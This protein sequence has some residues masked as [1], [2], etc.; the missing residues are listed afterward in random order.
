MVP[1]LIRI[2]VNFFRFKHEN[3]LRLSV[4]LAFKVDLEI[5]PFVTLH[6]VF[7]TIGEL[8]PLALIPLLEHLNAVLHNN[9][10][11]FTDVSL[12]GESVL[13]AQ[14]IVLPEKLLV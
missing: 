3:R 10:K 7:F 4:L 14:I 11:E 12:D 5:N 8:V 13:S 2:L 9:A 1:E 6:I